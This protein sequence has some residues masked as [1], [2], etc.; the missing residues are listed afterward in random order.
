MWVRERAKAMQTMP[1]I[2]GQRVLGL[3]KRSIITLI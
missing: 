1:R 3:S 2:M